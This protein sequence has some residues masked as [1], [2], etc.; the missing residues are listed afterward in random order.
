M[1]TSKSAHTVFLGDDCSCHSFSV[2]FSEDR[3][4]FHIPHTGNINEEMTPAEFSEFLIRLASA[5]N[6]AWAG[7]LI[8]NLYV[9][10]HKKPEEPEEPH[11][12]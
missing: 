10:N 1:V 9:T 4:S 3:A 7:D 6:C 11:A 5:A 8:I 12:Q 2:S